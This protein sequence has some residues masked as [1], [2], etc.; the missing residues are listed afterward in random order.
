MFAP[1]LLDDISKMEKLKRI[2]VVG[3]CSDI[4]VL[5]FALPIVNYFDELN[6]DVS[7]TV[8]SDLVETYDAPWHK[9]DEYNEMTV[10][11]LKQAGVK[12][13]ESKKV[14]ND[15]GGTKNVRK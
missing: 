3:C 4:F 10:K 11:L 1:G 6:K 15:L 9:R 13:E 7:V 8:I 2:Y 5:N 14:L 12:V